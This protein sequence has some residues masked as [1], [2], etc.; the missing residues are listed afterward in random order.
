MSRKKY[1]PTPKN[2]HGR[3]PKAQAAMEEMLKRFRE[4]NLGETILS[5][6]KRLPKWYPAAAWSQ[7]NKLMC[8]QQ[9]DT[10]NAMPIWYMKKKRRYP[11]PDAKVGY[12]LAPATMKRIV[13]D[14]EVDEKGKA[15]VIFRPIHYKYVPVYAYKD[16]L[17]KEIEGVDEEEIPLPPLA[18]VAKKVL[19][20]SII[21]G[22][23]TG[24]RLGDARVD[25]SKIRVTA[26]D[27]RTQAGTFF[28]ELGHAIDA[29][30]N[31]E[32]KG[33]QHTDSETVAEFTSATLMLMYGYDD[34]GKSAAYIKHYA[35][36]GSD[37]INEVMKVFG[38]IQKI[39]EYIDNVLL[40]EQND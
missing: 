23:L 2:E 22:F 6:R 21:Q 33:G 9:F 28:H 29:K 30:I 18:D 8:Q 15:V 10:I 39:M 1:K 24:D 34:F 7:G 19:G 20:I 13:L 17:G 31:G 11:K 3:T 12:I 5:T 37:P 14:N 38:R 35:E 27:E 16:T 40:E 36:Q 4:G 32:L 25:G 26:G